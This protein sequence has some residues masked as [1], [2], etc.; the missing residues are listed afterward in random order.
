LKFDL[1]DVSGNDLQRRARGA[2]ERI[3]KQAEVW[4]EADDRRVERQETVPDYAAAVECSAGALRD[5]RFLDSIEAVTHRVVHGGPNLH[6]AV[7]VDDEVMRAIDEATELAPLHNGPALEAIRAARQT[8]GEAMPMVAAFDTAFFVDLPAVAREYALP[9]DMRD[10]LHIRRYGF[11]GLAHRYMI[12]RFRA[13]RPQVRMPRLITLQLG[14]GCSITA[15]RDGRPLDTSMGYTPLEGL[16]MGTRSGD[17]DPM[18]PLLLVEQGGMTVD[19]VETLLNKQS[20]LLGLSGRSNDMRDLQVAASQGDKAANLAI[21]AFCYRARKYIGAYL[22]VLGGCDALVFG[23]G[24]GEHSAEIRQMICEPLSGCGV[25]L[26][27]QLNARVSSDDAFITTVAGSP[28]EVL[29][30]HVDEADVMARDAARI[31]E[32]EVPR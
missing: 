25:N 7:L 4:L 22:A 8:F 29:V 10:R 12:E 13:L 31:L 32:K 23:G 14:S 11:H 30:V 28:I 1:L 2:I 3:G 5:A 17:I 20:G 19:E 6:D 27:V 24:I 18:L 15:S 16:I 26:D 9:Q 21:E